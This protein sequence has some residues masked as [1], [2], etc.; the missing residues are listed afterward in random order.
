MNDLLKDHE[1]LFKKHLPQQVGEIL[2]SEL[3]RLKELDSKFKFLQEKHEFACESL[4][5]AN[6][7]ISEFTAMGEMISKNEALL[8]DIE[9]R[10]RNLQVEIL[11]IKLVE[12][13][14]RADVI[15]NLSNTVFRNANVQKS[16]FENGTL[17][18][19]SNTGMSE[20]VRSDGNK[21]ETKI[22]E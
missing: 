5:K 6:D 14:R 18:Y 3:L 13:E 15:Q 12:A 19:N 22:I 9:K 17:A 10:E 2:Q 16:V 20:W 21:T 7:K 11:T 1:E 4:R 8:T